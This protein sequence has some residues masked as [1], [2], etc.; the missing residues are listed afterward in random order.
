MEQSVISIKKISKDYKGVLAIDAVSLDLNQGEIF[1]FIGPNGAGKST[2]IKVLLNY[3]LADSGTAEVSGFDSVL[4]NKEIKKRVGYVSSEVNFYPEMSALEIIKLSMRLHDIKEETELNRLLDLFL[5]EKN[6]K[7]KNMSLGNKK[8]VGI[9]SALV[10]NTPIL[11]LDEPT[12]GLDPLMQ[13]VLFKELKRRASLG[14]TI[15]VSSHN[16]KEVQDHCD[17]VAFIKGGKIIQIVKMS[18]TLTE[19]K[20]VRVRGEVQKLL[21]LDKHILMER[22]NEMSFI[23]KGEISLLISTLSHMSVDNLI[24]ENL[25][26]EH[27]FLGYYNEGEQ[28]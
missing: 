28:S 9:V 8:K 16:L 6:K 14:H 17:R 15:F 25:S 1:G 22:E 26:L 21:K 3:I 4:D 2:T 20:Y 18:E 12:N 7:I 5:I 27:Q 24:I 19:G 23:F 10:L 11:I 13:N